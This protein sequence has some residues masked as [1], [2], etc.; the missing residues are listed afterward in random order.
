[1]HAPSAPVAVID[2][3][4]NSI[5]TLIARRAAGG[6]IE[7]L[8]HRTLDCRISAGI[9]AASPRLAE[10]GMS[11]G[12]AAIRE[13]LDVASPFAPA[14]LALVA[15][16]AVRDAENG[17][18]FRARVL[19]ATGHSIRI[20][21]GEDEA[22]LI[23]LGLTSDPALAHLRDFYVFDL[24]GGSL[25]CL[26]FRER[27]ITQA[28]S[29][30][31]G[32]VRL[33]EKFIAAPAAP[34]DPDAALGIALHV[35]QSLKNSGFRFDLPPPAAGVFTGGT[36]STLR[37]LKGALHGVPLAETPAIVPVT[38]VSFV[39]DEIAPL[40]LVARR[41]IPGMPQARA[42][43]FPAALLT[44]L[45]VAETASLDRFHHSLHNLRWGLAA[46]LLA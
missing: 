24:G 32:C 15:T 42:D 20:L 22:T 10:E 33:T 16:S 14:R 41:S 6:T 11:Q 46:E 31:L 19:A 26:A 39:L 37:A 30:P 4:S 17:G 13:L 2:I 12:L 34:L 44:V 35:R 18:E 29:L 5:K 28:L 43:V 40:D 38:Q 45:A 3:G 36:M 21:S 7:A 27:R 23:G 9:S 8:A 25:E 1:M